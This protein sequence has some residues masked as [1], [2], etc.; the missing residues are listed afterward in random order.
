MG[1][2]HCRPPLPVDLQIDLVAGSPLRLQLEEAL[3]DAVRSGRLAP[4]SLLP[5]SRVLAQELSVSRGVVVD[6]YSQLVAEGYLSATRGSGTRVAALPTPWGLP[7]ASE[8]R[9]Q[10]PFRYDLR[11]GQADFHAFP[12]RRW[13]AALTR[14][15]R[16]LPDTRLTYAPHRGAPELRI[17]I[18]AY[19]RRA[20][21]VVAEADQVVISCGVS[22]GLLAVLAALR[23]R[24]A[25][26]IAV[27]D[28]GWRWQ[29][30]TV[31]R[32]GLEAVPV[33][34]DEEG[35]IVSDLA[36][37]GADA[38]M[39]T[40]AHQYPTG[41]VLSPARR[42]AL[43][44]WARDHNALIL[45]DDYDAEYRYDR[46]PVAA[47]Q[48]LAP[49][50]VAY[51]GTVSKTLAPALRIGWIVA[52]AR[53]L[54]DVEQEFRVSAAQPPTIDQVALATLVQ[55]GGLD[56]HLRAM[57][58]RYR[59]KRELL[60]DTLAQHAA[61]LRISG[62]AAG[63]HVMAWLP[64]DCDEHAVALRAG[65]RSVGVHELHRNC[66]TESAWPPALLLGYAL[67]TESEITTGAQLL[68]QAIG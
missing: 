60:I 51:V 3:R 17:A 34:V 61:A 12:R 47:L 33:R 44:T 16:E 25:R 57:R 15:L 23:R 50:R 4:G 10:T 56:R 29:R 54:G 46:D 68:A 65:E 52:P 18:A 37:Q 55:D 26:R 1:R 67:P 66:M 40:A 59:A 27:E 48:S 32:A 30:R 41:V 22:H 13:Q 2:A 42:E 63:L 5:P 45:E 28:P 8:P 19:L 49:D 11:P 24:G 9:H 36:T 38:V 31:V 58:R 62:E 7:G 53:L 35:L 20:R 14:A 43:I 39:V 64:T 6:S 21:A